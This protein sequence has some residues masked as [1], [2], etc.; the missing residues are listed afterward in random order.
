[1][2]DQAHPLVLQAGY[3]GSHDGWVRVTV[4]LP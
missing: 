2:P 3:A 4:T 1:M